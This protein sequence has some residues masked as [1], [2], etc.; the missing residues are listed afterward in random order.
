MAARSSNDSD[1]QVGAA[2][3]AASMAARTSSSVALPRVP[4]TACR[5]CGWTT[6][7]RS[8]PPSLWAPPIVIVSS[9]RSAVSSLIRSSRASR[10]WL[11]GAYDL[12]GSLTGSGTTVTASMLA[13]APRSSSLM[14][15]VMHRRTDKPARRTRADARRPVGAKRLR[16][17][18]AE[19]IRDLLGGIPE[20]FVI[21]D[22]VEQK[23][24]VLVPCVGIR[25]GAKCGAH[26]VDGIVA[27]DMHG[28]E[29]VNRR[30]DGHSHDRPRPLI[31]RAGQREQGRVLNIGGDDHPERRPR[32]ADGQLAQRISCGVGHRHVL[33][34]IDITVRVPLPERRR[35]RIGEET[36][37]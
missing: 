15:Y 31:D 36:R 29:A 19:E 16:S 26:V 10:S 27:V 23:L 14:G 18:A 25:Y 6:S 1:L 20:Q 33:E 22:A 30:D 12:T 34:L 3:R 5:L 24:G 28:S 35:D 8:P 7:M 21:F 37:R 13:S 9:T 11:P 2:S 17:R 32:S 4:R